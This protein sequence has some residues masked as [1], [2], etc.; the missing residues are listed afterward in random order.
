MEKLSKTVQLECEI[1]DILFELNDYP[2]EMTGCTIEEFF[3]GI[4][5]EDFDGYTINAMA[6][7]F[8]DGEQGDL[9]MECSFKFHGRELKK[10]VLHKVHVF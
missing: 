3:D 1:D 6:D 9:S 5:L 10:A 8:F 4:C 2:G 7:L